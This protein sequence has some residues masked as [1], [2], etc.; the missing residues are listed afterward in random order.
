MTQNNRDAN[1]TIHSRY[2]LCVAADVPCS[3]HHASVFDEVFTPCCAHGTF[4]LVL[5]IVG[6]AFGNN[7]KISP[8][9]QPLLSNSSNQI[10]VIVQYKTAPQTSAGGLL[11]G[12]LVG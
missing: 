4:R 3:G 11:G 5:L 7:S 9:L 8:D 1:A 2:D 10:N 12:L 6:K